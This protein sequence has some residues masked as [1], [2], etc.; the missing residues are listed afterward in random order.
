[1]LSRLLPPGAG[2]RLAMG[3]LAVLAFLLLA[4][5]LATVVWVSFFQGKIIA[6]PPEGYTLSWYAAA[7]EMP[8]FRGGLATS[9]WVA[10]AAT[11]ASLAAGVPAALY[12]ARTEFR[13]REAIQSVLLGPLIVPGIVAGL[14]LY[15]FL[16]EAEILTGV[17]FAQTMGG[18][19]LGHSLIA[20][21]WT[22]RLVTAALVGMDRQ[23]EEAAAVMGAR[24]LAV[25]FLVTLPAIR[26]GLVAGGLFSFV[27]SFVDLEKSLFLVGP[28]TTTLPI[29]IINYLEWSVDPTIAAVATAQIAA[30]SAVMIATDRVFKLTRAF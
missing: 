11:A 16:I 9:L 28:G 3:T 12:L 21:P 20:L 14:A 17:Q 23:A 10:L 15:M 25:F 13:G 5:P 27:I 8:R 4:G 19:V 18:L 24:P 2:F 30:I 26:S 6:F 29:A 22:V 1:M 7:W